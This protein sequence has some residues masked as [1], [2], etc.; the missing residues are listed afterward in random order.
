MWLRPLR[1]DARFA[2]SSAH[3]DFHALHP[4]ESSRLMKK[5]TARDIGSSR[6]AM[7]SR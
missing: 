2:A 4:R 3:V 5:S 6:G 1:S 7:D